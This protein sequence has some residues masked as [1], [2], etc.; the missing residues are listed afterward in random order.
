[1]KHIYVFILTCLFALSASSQNIIV[2]DSSQKASTKTEVNESKSG[3]APLPLG[4]GSGDGLHKVLLIPYNPMMHLSD[5]DNDIAEYSGKDPE[6]LRK[7]FRMGLMQKIN[8]KIFEV[9]DSQSLLTEYA[10]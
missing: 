1:M 3:A 9:Y 6:T 4:K 2:T 8:G 5:A 10:K 7:M